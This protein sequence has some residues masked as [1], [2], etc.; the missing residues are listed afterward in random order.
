MAFAW[1]VPEEKHIFELF[2]TVLYVDTTCDTSNEG[3]PL[4]SINGIDTSSKTLTLVKAF[5]PNQQMWT[6]RWVLCVLLPKMYGFH[7]LSQIQIIITD[8]DS[9][10]TAQLDNA[11]DLF[12][13][14]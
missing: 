9:Q 3:R 8:G 7:I 12:S 11:V 14:K 10:E 1:T 13:H 5:L 6:F 4:L 2:P